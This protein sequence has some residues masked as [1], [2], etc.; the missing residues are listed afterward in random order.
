MLLD[1]N[2]IIYAARPEHGA[3]RDFIAREVPYVSVISKVE[4][5]GYHELTGQEKQF[6]EEFFKAAGVLP[7]SHSAIPK[8]FDSASS[9]ACHL[10]MR[11]SLERRSV[12]ACH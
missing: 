4:T 9:A 2:L 1:S 12:T 10:A 7:V 6:L 8:R 11:L 5:L 3:L